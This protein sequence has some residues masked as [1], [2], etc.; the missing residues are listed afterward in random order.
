MR[1]AKTKQVRVLYVPKKKRLILLTLLNCTNY[2]WAVNKCDRT[3]VDTPDLGH[4]FRVIS[5]Q[6]KRENEIG[7]QTCSNHMKWNHL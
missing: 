7:E 3:F 2:H 5:G 1:H 4:I 6:V